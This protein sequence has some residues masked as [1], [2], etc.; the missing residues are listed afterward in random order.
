MKILIVDDSGFVRRM[1]KKELTMRMPDDE[2]IE[3]KDGIDGL[4]KYRVHEPD[5]II[6][7]LLMPKMKGDEMVMKI[8]KVDSEIRIIVFSADV[9]KFIVEEMMSM[10]VLD[11]IH[12]PLSDSKIE[13]ICMLIKE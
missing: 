7:D 8:R 3:A 13:A 1:L 12:K 2:F 4:E 11:F 9:Q 6:T 10:D 5:V